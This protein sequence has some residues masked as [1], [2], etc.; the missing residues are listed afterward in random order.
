MPPLPSQL[1]DSF[2]SLGLSIYDVLVLTDDVDVASFFGAVLDCGAPP[3]PA[4]NWVQGDIMGHCK[5]GRGG[6]GGC[7][8]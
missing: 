7:E 2:L 5:V 1:R 6:R 8:G 3:K 4:A